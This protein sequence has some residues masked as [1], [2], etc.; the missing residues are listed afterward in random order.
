MPPTN[1]PHPEERPEGAR[2][3]GS[4]TEL[5][6]S[7]RRVHQLREEGGRTVTLP[8]DILT[9]VQRIIFLFDIEKCCHRFMPAPI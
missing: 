7:L 3:E 4:T 1:S 5:Q 9:Y 6:A 2:L 8:S